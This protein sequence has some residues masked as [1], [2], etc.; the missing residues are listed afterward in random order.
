MK[1]TVDLLAAV[2]RM[3]DQYRDGRVDRDILRKWIIGLGSYPL[4]YGAR[5]DAAKTWFGQAPAEVTDAVR[6]LDMQ[7]LSAIVL[8]APTTER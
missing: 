6:D 8:A 5:V 7:H 3:R 1:Q 4:P 2:S